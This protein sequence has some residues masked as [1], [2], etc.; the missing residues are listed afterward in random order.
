M[1]SLLKINMAFFVLTKKGNDALMELRFYL[2]ASVKLHLV[3]TPTPKTEGVMMNQVKL[4]KLAGVMIAICMM[5]CSFPIPAQEVDPGIRPV[6][7]SQ[8]RYKRVEIDVAKIYDDTLEVERVVG[9]VHFKGLIRRHLMFEPGLFYMNIRFTDER[10][11]ATVQHANIRPT[12]EIARNPIVVESIVSW[13][14]RLCDEMKLSNLI[15]VSGGYH[16]FIFLKDVGKALFYDIPLQFDPPSF[17]HRLMKF[18]PVDNPKYFMALFCPIK[19]V[20]SAYSFVT[21]KE[22]SLDPF[23]L[24]KAAQQTKDF[25]VCGAVMNN[26]SIDG[27]AKAKIVRFLK[28]VNS[29]VLREN[30]ERPGYEYRIEFRSMRDLGVVVSA[31]FDWYLGKIRLIIN[32]QTHSYDF[33]R[34]ADRPRNI[35]DTSDPANRKYDLGGGI[36]FGE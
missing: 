16:N 12:R 7:R 28:S 22:E 3:R 19:C 35:F 25:D 9:R 21:E 13:I 15:F 17:V 34:A 6:L 26:A 36:R 31:D 2:T 27:N 11:V 29:L 30:Q 14:S 24:E 23:A 4:R 8:P 32:T 18:E 5:F 33:E 10:R 20:L 1:I